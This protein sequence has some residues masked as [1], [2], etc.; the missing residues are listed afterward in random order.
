MFLVLVNYNNPDVNIWNRVAEVTL[1]VV[2]YCSIMLL[3]PYML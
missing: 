3:I 2:Y 1:S